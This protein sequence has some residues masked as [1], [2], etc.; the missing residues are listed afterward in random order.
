VVAV[1]LDPPS[2]EAAAALDADPVRGRLDRAPERG[3]GG[4]DGLDPVG[5]RATQLAGV[6][7]RR[8]CLGG[9]GGGRDQGKL[10]DRERDL[11]ALDPR[12]PQVGGA[13]ADR[14]GGLP[15]PLTLLDDLDLGAHPLED[16]EQAGA[17][18]VEADALDDD[19]APRD[20][21]GADDEEGGRGKVRGDRDPARIEAVGPPHRHRPVLAPHVRARRREHAL[22][23]VAA[24]AGLEDAGLALG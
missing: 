18:R 11:G 3:G 13:G 24:G 6:G 12:R 9:A 1:R 16:P 22:G 17:G 5:L 10:V 20:E 2:P 23:V 19:V 14:A 15:A 8:R 7:D 21:Q 4:G